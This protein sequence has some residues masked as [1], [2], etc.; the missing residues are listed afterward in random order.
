[1]LLLLTRVSC[2]EVIMHRLKNIVKHGA[3]IP[4]LR[5]PLL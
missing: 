3:W 5:H 1:L 2:E 4:R